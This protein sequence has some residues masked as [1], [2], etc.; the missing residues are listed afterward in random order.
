M[1]IK[2]IVMAKTALG[3][4]LEEKLA[5][6]GFSREEVSISEEI[7]TVGHVVI[8]VKACT[9]GWFVKIKIDEIV[10]DDMAVV[11]DLNE[12]L[13]H[14]NEEEL[15]TIAD[16]IMLVSDLYGIQVEQKKESRRKS[17]NLWAG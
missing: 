6:V 11:S 8:T 13:E 2:V 1:Y 9:F 3:V 14:P 15:H 12:A 10:M 5:S 4:Q 7:Y 16:I 17:P